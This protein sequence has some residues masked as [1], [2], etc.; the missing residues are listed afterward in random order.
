MSKRLTWKQIKQ[1]FR[2][3]W[4]ELVE[5]DW[6]WGQPCPRAAVVRHSAANRSDLVAEIE[7]ADSCEGS[8]ILF[9]GHA[10]RAMQPIEVATAL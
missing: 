4:V 1:E 8:M 10:Q 3:Q 6:D 9:I 7:N 2:G 5:C